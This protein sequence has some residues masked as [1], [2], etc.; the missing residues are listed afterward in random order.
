MGQALITIS[1][2][3][4]SPEA[5]QESINGWVLHPGCNL[6]VSYNEALAIAE[7]DGD[8]NVV[9]KPPPEEALVQPEATE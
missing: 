4:D 5:A 2:E 8:G 3:A 7:T 6:S 9:P 1:F